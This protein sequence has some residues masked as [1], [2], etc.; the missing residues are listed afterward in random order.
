MCRFLLVLY[1]F[2][3]ST[4][5]AVASGF[6]L[7]G[8]LADAQV[9][10][11]GLDVIPHFSW[12]MASDERGCIQTS[13]QIIIAKSPDMGDV[14][15]DSG[16]IQS[17]DQINVEVPDILSL[18]PLSSYYWQVRVSD[19]YGNEALSSVS[20]FT[21]GLCNEG[22]SGAQ[23]IMP[24]SSYQD[25]SMPRFRKSIGISKPIKSA[26][27]C[28]SA[29]GIYNLW[30]NGNRVGHVKSD[31]EVIYEE[32]K[33][34]WTDYRKRVFY[35]TYDVTS[36]LQEGNNI[37]AAVVS[38]GWWA[39]HISYGLYG[40]TTPGFIGKLVVAYDDNTVD[41]YVTDTSWKADVTGPLRI[42]ELYDGED[43]D[44]TK[45]DSWLT[46]EFDDSEWGNCLPNNGFT[47]DIVSYKAGVYCQPSLLPAEMTIYEG[48]TESGTDY[49]NLKVL[50]KSSTLPVILKKDQTMIVDF[51]QNI[52]GWVPFTIKGNAGTNVRFRYS[53]MLNDDGS[54]SRGNDGPGGSLYLS[55]LRTAKATLNYKMKGEADGEYYSTWS[56]YYGFRYCEITADADVEL[57]EIV[58]QPISSVTTE[59]GYIETS[60]PKIN[61]LFSNIR[62]GQRGNFVNIPTDCPQRDERWGWTGDAQVFCRTG[63]YN[64]LTESFYR[65][66]LQDLRDSQ[67]E[68]GIYPEVAPHIGCR[69]F[70][71]AGWGDAGIIIPYTLY[72]MYGNK[73]ILKE[74]FSS[75]EKYMTW[76]SSQQG[77]GYLYQGAY[78]TFGDW[79]AYDKCKNRYV[80]VAYYAYDAQLMEKMSRALSHEEND[81]YDQKAKAYHQLFENIKAEFIERFWTP[82]PQETS[83]T[84]YILALAFNLLDEE[85]KELAINSLEQSIKNNNGLLSTGFLGTCAY[86]PTLSRN[87]RSDLAYNLLL[88][89]G[90]PSWLYSVNQ[91]AT[92]IWERWDSYTVESG[93][94]PASMNSFNHYAYGAVGEWMYRFM[95]GIESDENEPGFKHFI[96]QPNPDVRKELPNG[97]DHI[98]FV[99]CN[100]ESQY[101]LI[102]SSWQ[103]NSDESI[104][105][106]CTIPV[107]TTATLYLPQLSEKEM[108]ESGKPLNKVNGITYKGIENGCYV[109]ELTS[110][111]YSFSDKSETVGISTEKISKDTSSCYDRK[112]DK[113]ILSNQAEVASFELYDYQGRT[114]FH[115]N[116]PKGTIDMSGFKKGNYIARLN[117]GKGVEVLKFVK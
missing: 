24:N 84:A 40:T 77:E 23:W 51:G 49:G 9:E 53:E 62:W 78:T 44:A 11:K 102:T 112:S 41:T 25:A 19:N 37:I 86:L 79:L 35:S 47:G 3:F 70:G 96:L 6:K 99:N 45:E 30:L 7:T 94:G 104:T 91:G 103:K 15:Y 67:A 81:E 1:I 110:G 4:I 109:M 21:T 2:L 27:L 88:Q 20:S 48:V 82:T 38:A 36:Y 85:R 116:S 28:T 43:Y 32:L 52:V 29:L 12:S 71:A 68:D 98:L 17:S 13:Y 114:I 56:T 72:L 83:Q 108:M 61:Q 65:K 69:N 80:S 31:E 113:I 8:T 92:T 100:Y 16:T 59:V 26:F 46:S 75:M 42:G 34:G 117:T 95:S 22:W 54:Q 60:N 76:L 10:P 57:L 97:Q 73:D 14:I 106:I 89:E 63:I 90:N 105:Y 107:N 18:T 33:P 87:G 58:G 55:N 66:Y 101:G 115:V 93:F 64:A 111:N 5:S 74:H 50:K 39:G